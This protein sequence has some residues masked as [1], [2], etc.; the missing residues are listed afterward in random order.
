MNATFFTVK[1][2]TA[3]VAV[4]DDNTCSPFVMAFL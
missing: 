1:K 4:S 3:V 2:P